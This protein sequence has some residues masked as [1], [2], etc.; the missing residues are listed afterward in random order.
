MPTGTEMED[1]LELAF[2]GTGGLSLNAS[3]SVSHLN[4]AIVERKCDLGQGR[5]G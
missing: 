2:F 4:V 3:A 1:P 5:D